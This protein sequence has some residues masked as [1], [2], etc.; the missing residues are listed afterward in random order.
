MKYN[1]IEISYLV[2][3]DLFLIESNLSKKKINKILLKV[4]SSFKQKNLA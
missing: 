4:Y 3:E 2:N 1:P